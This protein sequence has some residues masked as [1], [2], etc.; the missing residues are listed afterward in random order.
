MNGSLYLFHTGLDGDRD[1]RHIT[2]E[3]LAL[4]KEIRYFVVEDLRSSRRFLRASDPSFPID[5]CIFFE[6]NEHD[7]ETAITQGIKH[8]KEGH[9][10]GLLSEAGTPAVADPGESF[11]LNCHENGIRVIPFPGPNSIIMTLMSSGLN[12]QAF[13]F[14]GYLPVADGERLQVLRSLKSQVESTG[15]TQLFIETPYRSM[16][17][18]ESILKVID[19]HVLLCIGCNISS[20]HERILTGSRAFWTKNKPD[21]NKQLCVFAIGKPGA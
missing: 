14:H 5:D 9:N 20:E 15:Y 7:R 21:L 16:A 17:M 3:Q 18:F 2:P 11:V 6:L 1:A 8:I 12:G 10:V 13:T 4:L 19:E